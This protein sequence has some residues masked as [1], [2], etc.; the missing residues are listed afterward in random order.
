MVLERKKEIRYYKS[1]EDQIPKGAIT[2][3]GASVY[4]HVEK[5]AKEMG[6]YFNIRVGNRDF[7]LRADSIEEKAEWVKTIKA[8]VVAVEDEEKKKN[9]KELQK[10]NSYLGV[11]KQ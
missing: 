9:P 2:L 5:K 3:E 4:S 11:V 7:L 1:S 10:Q 8:N 6:N